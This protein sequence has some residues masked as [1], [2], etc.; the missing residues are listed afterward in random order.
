LD[1]NGRPPPADTA[2]PGGG[3]PPVPPDGQGVRADGDSL[4]CA[5]DKAWWDIHH[6]RDQTWRALQI[7]VAMA[8]G[9]IA[10]DWQLERQA[11]TI[12]ASVLVV[13]AAVFGVAVAYRHR[14]AVEERQWQVI[15][16]CERDLGIRYLYAGM[17]E[18]RMMR[19]R[20]IWVP[21]HTSVSLFIIRMQIVLML[22]ACLYAWF[23][24]EVG[25]TQATA[26][27]AGETVVASPDA[28]IP[29]PAPNRS[30]EDSSL[31]GGHP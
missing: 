24:H 18:P 10:I 31:K 2:I 23:R 13:I 6:S 7:V 4:R 30:D 12:A 15:L 19:W 25:Y 1:A 26:S 14:K 22:F 21:W 9:M 3:E 16:K 5:L 17:R 27:V 20:E 29:P 8:A 11:A 28:A